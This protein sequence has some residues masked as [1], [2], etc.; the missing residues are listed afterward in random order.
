MSWFD[1]MSHR[2]LSDKVSSLD[3]W[4]RDVAQEVERVGSTSI[5]E[6]RDVPEQ[7]TSP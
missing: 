5:P 6:R 3:M 2:A 7:G 4:G 1:W